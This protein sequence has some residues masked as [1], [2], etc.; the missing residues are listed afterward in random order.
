MFKRLWFALALF[1]TTAIPLATHAANDL[2]ISTASISPSTFTA[3]E[4][5]D[6][7]IGI[8]AA[9]SIGDDKT[10][11]F[12][13]SNSSLQQ[14]PASSGFDLSAASIDTSNSTLSATF[15]VASG[16]NNAVGMLDLSSALSSGSSYAVVIKD[17]TITSTASSSWSLGTT[18]SPFAQGINYTPTPSFTVEEDACADIT[19]GDLTAT[20]TT[21]A[22]GYVAFSWDAVTDAT[23]YVIYSG[24]DEGSLTQAVS[25][26]ETSAL[27]TTIPENTN[28]VY[29]VKAL[30]VDSCVLAQNTAA[31]AST[32]AL[33]TLSGSVEVV[34]TTAN[35]EWNEITN[36]TG[37][38]VGY[39]TAEDLSDAVTTDATTEIMAAISDLAAST[40]YYY[41]V[42]VWYNDS[43]VLT[44][45]TGAFTTA[46]DISGNPFATTI[47]IKKKKIKRTQATISWTA[48]DNV[49]SYSVQLWKKNKRLKTFN[50]ITTTKKVIQNLK[51][52]LGYKVRVRAVYSTGEV[53]QWSTYKKF[54]TVL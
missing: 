47:T 34:G 14:A 16:Q 20:A 19:L 31:T 23:S 30:N 4:T 15:S 52:G 35:I 51:P 39:S 3:G 28:L 36:A 37:Y 45:E 48:D 12:F 42:T 13:F 41:Q 21:V 5:T 32:G 11:T 18:F 40:T 22:G 6:I 26:T 54:Q 27:A 50:D 49:T 10:L 2:G 53:S 46:E 7:T 1:V 25:T 8:Q 33:E 44:S 43:S 9:A 24:A 17:V 29:Q 38:T